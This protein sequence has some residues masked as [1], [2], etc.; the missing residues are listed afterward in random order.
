MKVAT[1]YSILGIVTASTGIVLLLTALFLYGLGLVG[2]DQMAKGAMIGGLAVGLPGL[3]WLWVA[4]HEWTW[5]SKPV[6]P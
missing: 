1:V 2:S 5:E 6:K 3:V 4:A